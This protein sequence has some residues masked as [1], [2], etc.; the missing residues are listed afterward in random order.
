MSRWTRA[1]AYNPAFEGVGPLQ[2]TGPGNRG[3]TG[4]GGGDQGGNSAGPGVPYTPPPGTNAPR[5]PWTP[6]GTDPTGTNTYNHAPGWNG[7]RIGRGRQQIFPPGPPAPNTPINP[8]PV[9]VNSTTPTFT[10]RNVPIDPAGATIPVIYG[11]KDFAAATLGG[12]T[13]DKPLFVQRWV[14]T[15]GRYLTCYWIIGMGP[16]GGVTDLSIS[17]QPF[18]ALGLTAGVNYNLHTGTAT[19]GIDPL[20]A[21]AD[22][23]GFGLSAYP[24]ICYLVAVLDGNHPVASKVDPQQLSL[25]IT[26]GLPVADPRTGGGYLI[27]A[28]TAA[29]GIAGVLTGTYT[30]R[31]SM[32]DIGG[33]ES[34]G[35]ATSNVVTLSSQKGALTGISTGFGG[36]A[37]RNIYRTLGTDSAGP[38]FFVGN[39]PDNTTTTFTDN[40]AD[41]SLGKEILYIAATAGGVLNNPVLAHLDLRR[42][43]RYGFG[44]ADR[45]IDWNV[46]VVD[47]VN[48]CDFAIASATSSPASAPTWVLGAAYSGGLLTNAPYTWQYTFVVNGVETGSSAAST[49]LTPNASQQL[50]SVT[51]TFLTGPAGTTSRRIYR[52]KGASQAA[53]PRYLV[54]EIFDNTTTTYVDTVFDYQ[55]QSTIAPPT[56]LS[57][58]TLPRYSIGIVCSKRDSLQNW[59]DTFRAHYSGFLTYDGL[60]HTYV[61]L[62]RSPTGLA[63]DTTNIIGEIE[64]STMGLAQRWSRVVVQFYNGA[65]GWIQDFAAVEHPYWALPPTEIQR[66]E[67]R[68]ATLQLNG[69]PSWDQA[70][71][72]ATQVFNRS[73]LN[74]TGRMTVNARGLRAMP[75]IVATVTHPTGPLSA[76]QVIITDVQMQAGG[77]TYLITFEFYDPSVYLDT[78]QIN[79]TPILGGSTSPFVAPPPPTIVGIT[80]TDQIGPQGEPVAGINISFAPAIVQFYR[81]TRIEHSTDGGVTWV[82]DGVLAAG[83]FQLSGVALNVLYTFRLYTQ[84]VTFVESL[85]VSGTI[86]PILTNAT[87]PDVTQ[88][89]IS[90][91]GF[92]E[93]TG[94]IQSFASTIINVPTIAPV[95]SA[96]S[97]GAVTAGTYG[98]AYSWVN[99]A[100]DTLMS[101]VSTVTV[102]GAQRINI[103]GFLDGPTGT[104]LKK[105]YITNVNDAAGQ[106]YE[107]FTQAQGATTAIVNSN[108]TAW[109]LPELT[110]PV[111]YPF[112]T[113]YVLYD[114]YG[115]PTQPPLFLEVTSST[116]PQHYN[117]I[118]LAPIV[119]VVGTTKYVNVLVYAINK[120]GFR[121]VG[122]AYAASGTGGLTF[123]GGSGSGG[124]LGTSD[125][126]STQRVE[127]ANENTLVAARKRIALF[128]DEEIDISGSDDPTNNQVAVTVTLQT[129]ADR[130]RLLL[131]DYVEKT[132]SLP[133]GLEEDFLRAHQH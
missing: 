86:T 41:G 94:P 119:H 1:G 127:V 47:A 111:Y 116:P 22:P 108:P 38:W 51:L 106:L 114:F 112:I 11:G 98:C 27:T 118:N 126:T 24:G 68:E 120:L 15:T 54:A 33:N 97:G 107:A 73:R 70:K 14:D 99:S 123:T 80:E 66:E 19:Q 43:V 52:N 2:A 20:L 132:G 130:F 46:S 65:R 3:G 82:Q 115:S 124:T 61:D 93:F 59:D 42:S 9:R 133:A 122:K 129:L 50:S 72:I 44:I 37:S 105:F 128:G 7:T 96:I 75:G 77:S 34:G 85:P 71:R 125:D 81:G 76:T 60:W 12:N 45:T 64:I 103:T 62:A 56:S 25:T 55:L 69:C 101:P 83:P 26:T 102:N 39:I 35:G 84:L 29:A 95:V 78:V 113:K 91:A 79:P 49:T 92:F 40:V 104:L 6:T 5:Q 131:A 58:G 23:Q 16:L 89:F 53:T 109:V 88:G 21:A 121:S 31:I 48:A 17:G 32:V 110:A 8:S 67:R 87:I 57:T 13:P 100:G 90:P 18:A 63:F 36:T 28:P 4:S 10:N 30:Y 117:P 74:K